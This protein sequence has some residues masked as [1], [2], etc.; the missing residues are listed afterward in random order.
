MR[1]A[2]ESLTEVAE[3]AYANGS[4]SEHSPLKIAKEALQKAREALA[5]DGKGWIA[6]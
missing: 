4:I 2:D 6:K 5:E 1:K 3:R